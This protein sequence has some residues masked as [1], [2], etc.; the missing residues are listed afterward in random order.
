MQIATGN[1]VTSE[2]QGILPH[3]RKIW[4]GIKFGNLVVYITTAKLKFAKISYAHIYMYV[5]QSRTE[6]PNLNPLIFLQLQRFWAQPPNLIP[7][8]ISGYNMVLTFYPHL[9]YVLYSGK[10]LREKTFADRQER[11]IS[12]RKL[13]RNVKTG[14]IMGVACLEFHGENFRGWLKN[15]EIRE[16][17]LPRKFP[18]IRYLLFLLYH[19]LV[20]FFV[21][22]C[23]RTSLF[24]PLISFVLS[25]LDDFL[26]F[27][28]DQNHEE[29]TR[30]KILSWLRILR[31]VQDIPTSRV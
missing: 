25:G 16:S 29:F 18:T 7:A 28:L 1:N 15:C 13:L 22:L 12:R 27:A 26:G 14:R 11:S 19:I 24:R 6:P 31:S 21:S 2:I 8:N 4:R 30:H 9:L 20:K 3:S 17:F 10:F 23:I 5:W